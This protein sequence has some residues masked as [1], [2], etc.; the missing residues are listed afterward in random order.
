MLER[1]LWVIGSNPIILQIREQRLREVTCPRQSQPKLYQWESAWLSKEREFPDSWNVSISCARC[2]PPGHPCLGLLSLDQA[3][4]AQSLLQGTDT[5]LPTL[6]S[7]SPRPPSDCLHP[8]SPLLT[9]TEPVPCDLP[10]KVTMIP[11]EDDS[12]TRWG[13]ILQACIWKHCPCLCLLPQGK[14]L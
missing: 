11:Y 8:F 5:W 1:T 13:K 4:V 3:L 6:L 12:G 9:P 2:A 7:C 14:W 10:T